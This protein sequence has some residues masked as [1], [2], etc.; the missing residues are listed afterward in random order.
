MHIHTL[1]SETC[2]TLRDNVKGRKSAQVDLGS[3]SQLEVSFR[4]AKE[5]I[6]ANVYRVGQKKS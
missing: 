5:R 3:E 2:F 1:C 6:L 4:Q